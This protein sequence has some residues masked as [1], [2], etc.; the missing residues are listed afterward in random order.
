MGSA[1]ELSGHETGLPK[2]S[3]PPDAAPQFQE[4]KTLLDAPNGG[5]TP[6]AGGVT[7]RAAAVAA[8]RPGLP[9]PTTDM[10]QLQADLE[11]HGY[12]I[13]EAALSPDV[14]ARLTQRT[15]DQAAAEAAAAAGVSDEISARDASDGAPRQQQVWSLANKG[16]EFVSLMLH[17]SANQ[18]VRH[19]LGEEFQLSHCA[20]TINTAAA[21][22]STHATA[23]LGDLG[24]DQW[25]MPQPLDKAQIV[26][27]VR[28]GS[29]TAE[30]A[31]R[32]EVS[33]ASKH[34]IAPAVTLD[35]VWPLSEL[36]ASVCSGSHKSGRHPTQDSDAAT[37]GDGAELLAVVDLYAS[38]GSCVVMDG[39]LW[40]S[41]TSTSKP[42]RCNSVGMH[43]KSTCLLQYNYCGPQFRAMENHQLSTRPDVLGTLPEPV[44]ALL[45]FRSWNSYGSEFGRGNEEI[46]TE[47][48][49]VAVG[50]LQQA[51]AARGGPSLA[52]QLL[53]AGQGGALK[54]Q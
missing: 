17:K 32:G 7:D 3:L 48:Q 33:S 51:D 20:A 54:P 38:P 49:R 21:Q 18:L 44:K 28:P 24:M 25:W 12:C 29:V 47:A 11:A 27:T 5:G 31:C 15:M 22:P 19:A 14:L 34:V 40:Q 42:S 1:H 35:V 8:T 10:S 37:D 4:I 39:R 43:C 53:E 16:E 9:K 6:E 26:P 13:I 23:A 36:V 2:M 30:R 46:Y 52:E 50:A 45:G 41:L